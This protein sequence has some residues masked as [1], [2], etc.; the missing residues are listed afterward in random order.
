MN[1]REVAHNFAYGLNAN[2]SN[3]YSKEDGTL[4]YSYSS[5]LA[6]KFG[7]LILVDEGT[8]TYSITSQ[9][10]H[11]NFLHACNHWDIIYVSELDKYSNLDSFLDQKELLIV[12]NELIRLSKLQLRAR[13]RDYSYEIESQ[14]TKGNYILEYGKIDKRKQSYK[15]FIDFKNGVNTEELIQ[16]SIEEEK[17]RNKKIAKEKFESN[18]KRFEDFTGVKCPYKAEELQYN[19]LKIEG[20]KLKTNSWVTVPLNEALLLY[21]AYKSGRDIVGKK[22]DY[23]TVLKANKKEVKI[24]CHNILTKELDRVLGELV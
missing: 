18:K 11:S 8:A 20:D 19:W 9:K 4:L 23:Y 22:I 24:G 5:L 3:F 7:S 17:A 12:V 15:M 10:H 16:K 2:G 21:K 1:N 6:R 13:T 14:I